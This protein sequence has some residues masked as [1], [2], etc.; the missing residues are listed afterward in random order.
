MQTSA[1][2]VGRRL[3]ARGSRQVAGSWGRLQGEGRMEGPWA[4]APLGSGAP[5]RLRS[6]RP[7]APGPGAPGP[8]P[9]CDRRVWAAAAMGSW[10]PDWRRG[11]TSE[12]L[13]EIGVEARRPAEVEAPSEP[14]REREGGVRA[15]RLVGRAA[16][17]ECEVPTRGPHRPR[18]RTPLPRPSPAEPKLP[19]ELRIGRLGAPRSRLGRWRGARRREPGRAATS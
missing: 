18:S 19:A 17:P 11:R 6:C 1:T 8:S 16:R 9:G 7:P 14:A 13:G 10:G 12:R 3:G 5:A 15:A 4:P 2:R